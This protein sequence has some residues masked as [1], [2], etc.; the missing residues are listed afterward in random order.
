M[1]E[2]VSQS[3]CKERLRAR[4]CQVML[5]KPFMSQRGNANAAEVQEKLPADRKRCYELE[6]AGEKLLIT[7][8]MHTISMQKDHRI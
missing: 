3:I 7:N 1:I 6:G 8:V 5:L 4:S 2:R